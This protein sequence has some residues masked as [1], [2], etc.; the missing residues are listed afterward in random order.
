M[1][2]QNKY[3]DF[4]GLSYFYDNVIKK[5]DVFFY[6]YYKTHPEEIVNLPKEI[7]YK[8]FPEVLMIVEPLSSDIFVVKTWAYA[9]TS[10]ILHVDDGVITIDKV[11]EIYKNNNW[12]YD[13]ASTQII[14][15]P[16]NCSAIKYCNIANCKMTPGSLTFSYSYASKPRPETLLGEISGLIGFE[17]IDKYYFDHWTY[18]NW[19]SDPNKHD[20][21]MADKI[22]IKGDW[23]LSNCTSLDH[24][25]STAS[26]WRKNANI[27]FV[28]E[29]TWTFGEYLKYNFGTHYVFDSII[30]H[31]YPILDYTRVKYT[32]EG[33]PSD[34]VL[35]VHWHGGGPIRDSYGIIESKITRPQKCIIKGMG[36]GMGIDNYAYHPYQLNNPNLT[37]LVDWDYDDMIAS[38]ITYA[39]NNKEN[40]AVGPEANI[41]P[42]YACKFWIT[43][44]SYDKLT[45]DD[46]A[47]IVA[48]GNAVVVGTAGV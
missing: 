28:F 48:M 13:P 9:S 47:A 24:M 4:K 1:S 22:Y 16:Y 20:L 34:R 31:Q 33:D 43:Q 11:K 23:D 26:E 19:G 30:C 12:E 3:L 46:L 2:T 42:S 35:G 39:N 38:L 45:E 14:L 18:C 15:D 17:K 8:Y 29:G 6:T 27:E 37:G 36:F 5:H 40:P 25:I 41:Y 21:C 10:P 32:G 7:I 44:K